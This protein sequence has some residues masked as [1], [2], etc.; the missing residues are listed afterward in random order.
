[1]L[2]PFDREVT[3]AA[4]LLITTGIFHLVRLAEKGILK[5]YSDKGF[6]YK[7]YSHPNISAIFEIMSFSTFISTSAT[8]MALPYTAN[9]SNLILLIWFATCLGISFPFWVFY[10]NKKKD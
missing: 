9:N 6:F 7:K 4:S 3:L 5:F 8:F 2:L 10:V 1:M